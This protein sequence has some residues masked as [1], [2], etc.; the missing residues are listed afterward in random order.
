MPQVRHLCQTPTKEQISSILLVE[1]EH[2]YE[3]PVTEIPLIASIT[4][5]L[6]MLRVYT[7]V[8]NRNAVE[9]STRKC[10]VTKNPPI[11]ENFMEYNNNHSSRKKRIVIKLKW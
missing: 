8:E 1:K 7:T 11:G 5:S 4:G 10:L 2:E 6:D 3:T 9:K